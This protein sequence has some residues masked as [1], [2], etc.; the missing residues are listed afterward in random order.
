M[1]ALPFLALA[2]S[3]L[4][5]AYAADWSASTAPDPTK[6]LLDNFR[7]APAP[8]S[9][10]PTGL[11]R[12][13]Y[14]QMIAGQVDFWKTKQ[15]AS[16]AIIDPYM[17]REHQYSTPAFA[18]AAAALVAWQGRKDLME[19]ASKALDWSI[20]SLRERRAADGHED[21]FPPMIAHAMQLL[22]PYVDPARYKDW[23]MGVKAIDPL[24]TYRKGPGSMNWNVV[25]ASGE[26]L[27]EKMGLRKGSYPDDSFAAQAVHF[28]TPY[29]LYVEGPMAYDI[30]P[31]MFW[32]DALA[33]GFAGPSGKPLA[34]LMRRAAITSL[35]MQSPWGEWPAG[36]RSAHHQWNEAVQCAVY[37]INA[38]EAQQRG[39]AFMAAV[40]KRAAH[41]ALRSM[42]RWLRPS[43]ELQIVKN[44][45]DPAQRHAYEA[46]SG[47]TQYNLLP[48]SMLALAAQYAEKTE[49]VAEKAAPADVGG[50]AFAIP[51]LHKIFANAGGTYLEID[52]LADPH[53]DAT[54]LVRVHTP[55]VSPQLGPSDSA[56]AKAAYNAP[57]SSRPATNT[58]IGVEWQDDKGAWRRVGEL[59]EATGSKRAELG[60]VTAAPGKVEFTVVYDGGRS[61]AQKINEHYTVTPGRVEVAASVA[62]AKG[63]LR[64]SWPV[65][66]DDGAHKSSILVTG[67]KLRV[68][69]QNAP[70]RL[71]TAPGAG[72]IDVGANIF[73]NHN[74]WVQIAT[75]EFPPGVQPKLVLEESK[76]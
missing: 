24:K 70:A 2:A 59:G 55:G 67:Y 41:L 13:D 21:F 57:G 1:K 43:G 76:N 54:G 22:R 11:G 44:H 72:K 25:A 66:F 47:N 60:A 29:G 8:A 32:Q 17:N 42:Q 19:P 36:G 53:Y 62:G 31:R 18:H 28:K 39:D 51:E 50:F 6:T 48:M 23:E 49:N 15:N 65:L 75:A 34:E 37:E 45:V 10:A 33:Q 27:F 40:Y 9:F 71:F 46:Y 26:A 64:F 16:G 73:P 12:A 38:V 35:F 30:F 58:G 4:S 20:R 3:F 7:K 74:G 14:L 52:T 68:G 69:Q 56:L 63:P 5:V 61:G